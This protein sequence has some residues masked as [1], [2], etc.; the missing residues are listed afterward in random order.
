L[1]AVTALTPRLELV[2]DITER[3]VNQFQAAQLV[4]VVILVSVH[5]ALAFELTGGWQFPVSQNLTG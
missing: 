3:G 5:P 4:Q 1:R 2:H